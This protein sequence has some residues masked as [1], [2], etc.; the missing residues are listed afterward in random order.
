MARSTNH[1]FDLRLHLVREAL[2]KGIRA[3]AALFQCSRN[4][5]RKW[6][7]RF[8]ADGIAG[9]QEQSRAPKTCPHKTSAEH[10]AQVLHCRRRVPCF[11]ARR[12]KREFA[13]K[14]SIS[15]IARILRQHG[16]TRS[17]KRRHRTKRDLRAVKAQ[18]AP[19]TRLQLDVKYLNDIPHY[20][21][22]MQRLGLPTYQYTTRCVRTGA[23]FLAYGCEVSQTYAE[24]TVR[25]VLSHLQAHGIDLKDVVVQTDRGS[26][27]DGQ[28]VHKT[29]RGF[30]HT[31]EQVFG[32][33]HRPLLRP[34]PNANAEVESFHAHE[35]NEFFDLESFRHAQDFW[36]KIT[37]YQHYWNLARPNAY[38]GD[39]TP[40]ER[41]AEASA[42]LS[43][44]ILLLPPLNL[45]NL[46][47][48]SPAVRAGVG[49]DVPAMP[50]CRRVSSIASGDTRRLRRI[51]GA[52]SVKP[53]ASARVGL[54]YRIPV[55]VGTG[56]IAGG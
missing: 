32:A 6:L 41:L 13:L 7:R 40:A 56:A 52:S 10:E 48:T 20:W 35:E 42:V 38:Q 22:Q 19:F 5:V 29:D 3:A 50:A 2:A 55:C 47:S 28:T 25:R 27:F 31:V 44:R 37:T 54:S 51:Y 36:E 45:D 39:K 11:S 12:L 14:P 4:T 46:P 43:P 34:N 53:A 8:E 24:L 30:T 16:L 15:A 49:H 33:H 18:Y 1:R 17:R 26:E 23:T 21:P 9:L